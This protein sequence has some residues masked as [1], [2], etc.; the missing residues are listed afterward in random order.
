MNPLPAKNPKIPSASDPAIS[1]LPVSILNPLSVSPNTTHTTGNRRSAT[2]HLHRSYPWMLAASTVV[3]GVFCLMYITKPVV[4]ASQSQIASAPNRPIPPPTKTIPT[5]Q[6]DRSAEPSVALPITE[7]LMPNQ[8]RLPG[9]KSVSRPLNPEIPASQS[10]PSP[11]FEL[12]NLRIQHILNADTPN[13]HLAK[14]DL[15]VPVLYQSRNL[16]WTSKE[17]N[18]AREILAG[19]ATYQEKTQSLRAE[20][21]LLLESWNRLIDHSI[22]ASE[23]RADSPTIPTNQQDAASTPLKPG[24]NSTDL[25]Q[26]KPAAK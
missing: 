11:V 3:S 20:G 21:T 19:L 8:D 24:L 23:L 26:I 17:V 1:S 16:R 4:Q 14:I 15:E 5:T 22:P 2:S 6:I 7:N 25:I 12:T 13:G 9:E 18:E 10:L